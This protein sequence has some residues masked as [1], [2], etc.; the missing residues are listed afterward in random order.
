[1][2]RALLA[3]LDHIETAPSV[4]A[5]A[6]LLAARLPGARIDA[7]HVRPE[8]DPRFMP[9]EEIMTPARRPHSAAGAAARAAALRGAF[10]AWPHGNEATWR[11]EAGEE[12]A[13]VARAGAGA[14]LIV[15]GRA[16]HR[17]PGNGRATVEA[18][19]FAGG[20]PLL[21]VPA[22]VPATLGAHVAVAWKP[23]AAAERAVVAAA[24]LLRVAGRVTV[25][26][27]VDGEDD[28][29]RNPPEERVQDL[30]GLGALPETLSFELG[31]QA[32]GTTLMR[33]ARGIGAD[34]MVMGA[35]A[36]SSGMEMLL[37]GATR[38]VLAAADMSI[39][40]HH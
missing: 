11:E 19:L 33:Q 35:Y 30:A 28:G 40:L 8:A 3:V 16:P 22:A 39:L 37:G 27:G 4:L 18:L 38:E 25:M 29:D 23:G 26:T 13:V 9:T 6:A 1:M 24:P 20:P 32:V 5:A 21:L 15:I 17:E 14:D 36:H 10:E 31:G 12:A 34:L 7:L 2:T